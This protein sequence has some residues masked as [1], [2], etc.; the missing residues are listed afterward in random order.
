MNAIIFRTKMT[1]LGLD[2]ETFGRRTGIGQNKITRWRQGSLRVPLV[3][4]RLID[5]LCRV[6]RL[7]TKRKR[8]K[9][10]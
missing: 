9:R 8:R 10:R 7:E 5:S 4:E 6:Q 2:A 3:I 1:F